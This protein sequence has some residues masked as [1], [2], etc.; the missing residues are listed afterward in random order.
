MFA[1]SVSVRSS[2]V[3]NTNLLQFKVVRIPNMQT[4]FLFTVKEM[5]D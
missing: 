5:I 2:A 4:D 3:A 1:Y